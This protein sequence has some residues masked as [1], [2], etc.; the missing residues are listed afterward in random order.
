MFLVFITC[1]LLF[2]R[3]LTVTISIEAIVKTKTFAGLTMTEIEGAVE[4]GS[5]GELARREDLTKVL[6]LG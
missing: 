3:P 1:F 5:V 2:P 4:A 6:R